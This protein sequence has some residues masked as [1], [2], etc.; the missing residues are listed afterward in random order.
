LKERA[1]TF[2]SS[3]FKSLRRQHLHTITWGGETQARVHCDAGV[4]D[5]EKAIVTIAG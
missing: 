3:K 4:A 5:T 2:Q 1:G